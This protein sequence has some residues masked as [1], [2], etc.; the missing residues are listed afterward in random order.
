MLGLQSLSRPDLQG[1]LGKVMSASA[2]VLLGFGAAQFIR[3]AT[4]VLLTRLLFPEAFGLMLIITTIII[5]L[6]LV[7]DTGIRALLVQSKR[8]EEPQ[9]L[10]TAYTVKVVR[11]FLL[12]GLGWALAAPAA[13]YFQKPEIVTLLPVAAFSMVFLGFVSNKKFLASRRLNLKQVTVQE[14]GA[15]IFASVV[16]IIWA[17]I[18]PSVWAL[19]AGTLAA[20]FAKMVTSHVLLPGPRDR[21]GWDKSAALELF[22]FGKWILFSTIL[23][24][25][26]GRGD[27]FLVGRFLTSAEL[28]VF[29]IAISLARLASEILNKV[30]G[31]VLFPAFAQVHREKPA[32]LHKALARSRLAIMG[33][34]L[35]IFA[36]LAVFGGDF[37]D[38]VYDP[39]YAD[40]GWMLQIM[41]CGFGTA[42]VARSYDGVLHA[43]GMS[44]ENT[45][46]QCF[47]VFFKFTAI[48]VGYYYFGLVG[49]IIGMSFSF[50]LSYPALALIMGRAGVWQPR[51]DI[52][53]LLVVAALT[54]A[55]FYY[56]PVLPNG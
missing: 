36:P 17:L 43:K 47:Q 25:L 6:E 50:W 23:A 22:N 7:S 45:F 54:V 29:A 56:L 27:V 28:G 8:G 34:A 51:L 53:A 11:G 39:R 9:V 46:L 19:A 30:S 14:V 12:W 15:Q 32:R 5:G 38:L 16:M 3:F 18:S 55:F 1:R 26:S 49:F 24:Y 42:F 37:V 44:R 40:A 4:N 31:G 20:A 35:V 33:V 10:A 21:L 52:A 13:A 48:L 41:A 2:W